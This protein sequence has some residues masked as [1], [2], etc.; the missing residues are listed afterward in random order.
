MIDFSQVLQAA[1]GAGI[2]GFAAYVAIRT[3]LAELKARVVN[4]E[5]NHDRQTDRLDKLV[6]GK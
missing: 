3:D 4:M 1:F 5:K 2:G 6:D